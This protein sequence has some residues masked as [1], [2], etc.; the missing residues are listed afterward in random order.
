MSVIEVHS[1]WNSLIR[2]LP[3]YPLGYT[4]TICRNGGTFD[5]SCNAAACL[6]AQH[7]SGS[8]FYA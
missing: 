8:T 4:G 3:P 7:L 6:A 5:Y 1:G 2:H